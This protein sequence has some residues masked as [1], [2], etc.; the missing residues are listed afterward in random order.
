V[1]DIY[2]SLKRTIAMKKKVKIP[3]SSFDRKPI[4]P[5]T[6]DAISKFMEY[7]PA[8]RLSNNLRSLLLE[9]LMYDGSSEAEYLS[10]LCVD[11]DGLFELLDVLDESQHLSTS[12]TSR[13]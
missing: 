1:L 8:K 3:E 13:V 9:F 12:N 10:D 7:Y 4:D 5:S 6:V 2:V 11:L